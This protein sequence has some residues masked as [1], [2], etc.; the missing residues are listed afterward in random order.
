MTQSWTTLG[1]PELK[2][3]LFWCCWSEFSSDPVSVHVMAKNK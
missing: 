2:P 1:V 3:G